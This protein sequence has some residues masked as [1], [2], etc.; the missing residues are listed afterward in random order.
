MKKLI[1]V[2]IALLVLP[3]ITLAGKPEKPPRVDLEALL[4]D[5][6]A[7]REAGDADLQNQITA[8]EAA[9]IDGDAAL[10]SQIDTI[11]CPS[12]FTSIESQGRQLGCM[13][14]D[15][16]GVGIYFDAIDNCFSIYGGRLP[17]LNEWHVA[18]GNY[19]LANMVAF[20]INNNYS[21]QSK[22]KKKSLY[23]KFGLGLR[24]TGNN[25]AHNQTMFEDNMKKAIHLGGLVVVYKLL[26]QSKNAQIEHLEIK[27][28]ILEQKKNSLLNS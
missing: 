19:N 11:S 10:Q 8:E 16:E 24:E 27:H 26:I 18:Y 1:V 17:K 21:E 23:K 7:A 14:N 9:R 4:A 2:L 13:Q 20:D 25:E 3:S 28:A 22:T 6:A 5:E 15:E 12:G